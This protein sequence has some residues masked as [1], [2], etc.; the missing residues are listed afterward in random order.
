MG[1]AFQKL[2]ED[3]HYTFQT[4][5]AYNIEALSPK[6]K[7]KKP[8]LTKNKGFTITCPLTLPGS[9]S[10]SQGQFLCTLPHSRHF[11]L[12]HPL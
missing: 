12:Y 3:S 2:R 7:K 5:L 10:A 4:N 1:S 6:A 9:P 8:P 11:I